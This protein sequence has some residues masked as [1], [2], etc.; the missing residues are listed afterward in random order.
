MR[1]CVG[2]V[3]RGGRWSR[4]GRWILGCMGW[5]GNGTT[6]YTKYTKRFCLNWRI[7]RVWSWSSR[8]EL[9]IVLLR[10]FDRLEIGREGEI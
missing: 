8:M 6:K 5:W 4:W 2:C 7:V 9:E 10:G 3:W 1:W